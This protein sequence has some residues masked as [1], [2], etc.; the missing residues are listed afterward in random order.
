MASFSSWQGRKIHG[1]EGLLTE[2][3]KRRMGFE[4]FVVGDWNA[5]GQVEG[6]TVTSCAA[7]IDAGLDMF[8]APDSW[9]GLYESTLAQ[10]RAG[11][12]PMARLDDAVRRVLLVKL[13]AGLFEAGKPSSR[14]PAGR[15][16]L[17]GSAEHRA[18]ARQA[19]RES[20]VLLKNANHILP[21][22]PDVDV[23]VAGDG[24]DS[25]PKQNGGWTLSWQG[26]GTTNANFPKAESIFSGIRAAVTAAGGRATLSPM[27]TYR[28]RP[29]AA[30]VVFGEEPYAEFQGDVETLEYK[31]GGDTDVELLRRLRAAGIPVVAVF[32]SGRPMWVNRELNAA[33]AFVAAWLPGS[34]GGGVADVLF[35]RRDGTPNH[36]FKGKLPFAWPRS[37]L[38]TT[39]QPGSQPPLFPC[40]YGLTYANEGALPQLSE[41]VPAQPT[42]STSARTYFAAGK[43]GHGWTLA[44]REGEGAHTVLNAGVGTSPTGALRVTAVDRA[45]QED[46]RLASWS[47]GRVATLALESATPVDLQREANGQLSLA[48]DYRVDTPPTGEVELAMECGDKCR[49]QFPIGSQLRAAPRGEWRQ[50]KVLLQCFQKSGADMRSISAP[51]TLTTAGPVQLRFANVRL[52]TGLSD[53]VSCD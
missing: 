51:F 13:R 40:G 12:I 39:S 18:V 21:L 28:K 10:V 48:F 52:D 45:A 47:G 22:N 6:C 20:L 36:D 7:A 50:L 35:A 2:V 38:Q 23:L 37:P 9:K 3:L 42:G 5:H 24:A 44:V 43:T 32:L 53:A 26:T 1:H 14:A 11:A 4:G 49:G 29:D 17:L 19:V 27:G 41:N 16:E 46:A 31:P 8:M 25:L 30:I 15:F 33:D 34:E